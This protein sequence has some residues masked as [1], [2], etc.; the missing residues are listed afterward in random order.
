MPKY[1]VQLPVS[2]V[3][4]IEVEADSEQAAIKAALNGEGTD[5]VLENWETH[6]RVVEGNVYHG[7]LDEA[8][9][10]LAEDEE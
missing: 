10:E 9:A 2:G 7:E 4:S 6:E 8:T 3:A 1:L 5:P